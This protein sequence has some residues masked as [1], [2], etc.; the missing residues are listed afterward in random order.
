MERPTRWWHFFRRNRWKRSTILVM[1]QQYL[2]W[3]NIDSKAYLRSGS[4]RFSIVDA[5]WARSWVLSLRYNSGSSR[6]KLCRVFRWDLRDAGRVKP[7][8]GTDMRGGQKWKIRRKEQPLQSSIGHRKG[9]IPK[10]DISWRLPLELSAKLFPLR[11]NLVREKQK[12]Q[13]EETHHSPSSPSTEK[14]LFVRVSGGMT[15]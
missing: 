5:V 10:W 3:R 15:A 12:K 2:L 9:L 1:N 13:I 8:K 11:S 4:S 6:F 14:G 7:P